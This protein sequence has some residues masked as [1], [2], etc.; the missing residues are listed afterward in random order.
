MYWLWFIISLKWGENLN[1]GDAKNQQQKYYSI[2][3][4]LSSQS[5]NFTDWFLLFVIAILRNMNNGNCRVESIPFKSK[6]NQFKLLK[7]D[8]VMN[9]FF[10]FHIF[11]LD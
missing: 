8:L 3:V 10:G 9:H 5:E 4:N 6:I 7:K 2:S 11:F 1:G